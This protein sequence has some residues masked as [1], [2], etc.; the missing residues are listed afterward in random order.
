MAIQECEQ[1]FESE[2]GSVD[3]TLVLPCV[4]DKVK[5]F[6]NELREYREEIDRQMEQEKR[7]EGI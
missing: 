7:K 1:E 3:Y 4:R 5:E 2:T 6:L